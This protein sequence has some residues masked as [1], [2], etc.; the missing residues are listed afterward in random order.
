MYKTTGASAANKK[1]HDGVVLISV[2]FIDEPRNGDVIISGFL[3]IHSTLQPE[4][5]IKFWNKWT[6]GNE[7]IVEKDR[8]VES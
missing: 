2:L 7:P 1:K 5:S 6:K 4:G 8:L 3:G